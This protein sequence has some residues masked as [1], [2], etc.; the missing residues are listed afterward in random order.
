MAGEGIAAH[1]LNSALYGGE[2]LAS[3]PCRFTPGEK[4]QGTHWIKGWVDLKADLD[5]VE[6]R[7]VFCPFQ[8]S[9]PDTLIT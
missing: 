9:N 8:E 2:W 3:R 6:K 7:K 4:A 1:I 5:T